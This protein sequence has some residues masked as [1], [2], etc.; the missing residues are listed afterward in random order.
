MISQASTRPTRT[1]KQAPS[2][3]TEVFEKIQTA[4][5]NHIPTCFMPLVTLCTQSNST[6]AR[7]SDQR[8]KIGTAH[9]HGVFT[10]DLTMIGATVVSQPKELRLRRHEQDECPQKKLKKNP[11][12]GSPRSFA[13]TG[14]SLPKLL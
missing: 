4:N 8:E 12:T 11:K 9:H 5:T 14:H 1:T 10:I 7:R 6:Q 3:T 13:K 2:S